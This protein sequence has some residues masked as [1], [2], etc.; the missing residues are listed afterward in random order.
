MVSQS[1]KKIRAKLRAILCARLRAKLHARLRAK[2][3][4]LLL[5]C[6]SAKK[7]RELQYLQGAFESYKSQV[8][9]EMNEKWKDKVDEMHKE[10]DDKFDAKLTELRKKVAQEKSAEFAR[11]EKNARAE[12][13]ALNRDH[14]R[15]VEA[16]QRK[17]ASHKDDIE[18]LETTEKDL[19]VSWL[20][21]DVIDVCNVVLLMV[22]FFRTCWRSTKVWRMTITTLRQNSHKFHVILP[23]L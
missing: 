8:L 16:M 15:E 3:L 22:N 5:W 9:M 12:I 6:V 17:F 13:L 18:K 19:A 2:F 10:Y 7:A 4:H 23:T 14:K 20:R 1:G 21:R 11:V